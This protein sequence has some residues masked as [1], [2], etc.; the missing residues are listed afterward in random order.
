ME[1]VKEK[2]NTS[3]DSKTVVCP[4]CKGEGIVHYTKLIS[5]Y[6]SERNEQVCPYCNGDRVMTRIIETYYERIK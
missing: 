1:K 4:T 5:A 2:F 3:K 6:E